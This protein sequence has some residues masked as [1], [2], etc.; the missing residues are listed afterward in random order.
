MRGGEARVDHL[1]GARLRGGGGLGGAGA[2]DGEDAD[3]ERR[4]TKAWAKVGEG[5]RSACKRRSGASTGKEDQAGKG[6]SE[7][8]NDVEKGACA[9]M[10]CMHTNTV[11][12]GGWDGSL[13]LAPLAPP[14]YSSTPSP[15]TL[16]LPLPML[17]L[18][19]SYRR[20]S[21]ARPTCPSSPCCNRTPP[22]SPRQP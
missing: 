9:G 12:S 11:A 5:G 21:R 18:T 6:R 22:P 10:G 17:L 7:I 1:R 8:V 2:R 20:R 14:Y 4:R 19:D 13:S 16:R 3:A 15:S